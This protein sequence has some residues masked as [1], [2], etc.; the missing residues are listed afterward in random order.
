M[1]MNNQYE[2]FYA[3]DGLRALMMLLGLVIHSFLSFT[4]VPSVWPYAD[5]MTS[6]VADLLVSFIHAFRMP[7]FFVIAGFFS[8]LLYE[9][10]GISGFLKNR[11]LR[12][13][14][15]FVIGLTILLPLF[16]SGKLFANLAKDIGI[17]TA[18]SDFHYTVTL[19]PEH[20][21]HLWFLYYLLHF[22]P[23]GILTRLVC[24][25]LPARFQAI[26][27]E[28]FRYLLSRP[29]LRVVTFSFLTAVPLWIMGGHLATS[30]SFQP[31]YSILLTYM[32]FYAFGWFLYY[33]RDLLH[34]VSEYAVAQVIA[35]LII[36]N[37]A[38]FGVS[39]FLSE[40]NL[41][42]VVRSL[43][44]GFVIWLM[45]FGFT[46][47]FLRYLNRPSAKI[48]YI[49]DAS[50]WVYLIHLPFCI[51]ITALLVET[52]LHAMVKGSI[53]LMLVAV[54]AFLSYDLVVRS[55][56]IGKILNGQRYA[57]A[58]PFK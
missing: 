6:P 52:G 32:A 39:S 25:S 21:L 43:V 27:V 24:N 19:V 37:F 14:L 47:L 50:Y 18:F 40:G 1:H 48:R 3:L 33:Q 57:R 9:K 4:D 31:M 11:L 38:Y 22:Y 34:N 51:W 56:L 49:V 53:V 30:T 10:R 44:G 5:P 7:I 12:I 55:T 35:G 15:P 28:L 41:K 26:F 42:T 2:R 54:I 23:L 36:F 16:A 29:I 8:G 20:T 46:G 45:F 17:A 58:F 13:A